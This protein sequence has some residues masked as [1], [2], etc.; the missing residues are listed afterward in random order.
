[1]A[2]S[3]ASVSSAVLKK[4]GATRAPCGVFDP[5]C[6]CLLPTDQDRHAI[7][8]LL[9]RRRATVRA[10]RPYARGGAAVSHSTCTRAVPVCSIAS[11][12]AAA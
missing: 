2:C 12:R 5:D 7:A 4:Q 11:C 6:A 3:S 9:L 1:M 10:L 8:P